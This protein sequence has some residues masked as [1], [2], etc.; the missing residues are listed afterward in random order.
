M[1]GFTWPSQLLDVGPDVWVI[2]NP[3]SYLTYMAELSTST[4]RFVQ[5]IGV[6]NPGDDDGFQ[7]AVTVCGGA[8]WVLNTPTAVTEYSA[9]TGRYLQTITGLPRLPSDAVS[10]TGADGHVWIAGANRL[11]ELAAPSGRLVHA[12]AET[13]G[14]FSTLKAVG[15]SLWASTYTPSSAGVQLT[16]ISESSGDVVRQITPA[17]LGVD[18]MWFGTFSATSGSLWM[19]ADSSTGPSVIELSATTGVLE[20]TFGGPKYGFVFP[21]AIAVLGDHVWAVDGADGLT[22]WQFAS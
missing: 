10:L 3:V 1:D 19:S 18:V 6:P 2:G 7:P 13:T 12:F 22:E 8:L 16:Q 14:L 4:G 17:S 15:H 5:M 9:T 21:P 20:A 11:I